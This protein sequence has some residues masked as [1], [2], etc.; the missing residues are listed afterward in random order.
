[1]DVYIH[2][3]MQYIHTYIVLYSQRMQT[4]N[5]R[6]QYFVFAQL[7]SSSTLFFNLCLLIC[8]Y[9]NRILMAESCSLNV[10]LS[11]CGSVG[12][13]GSSIEPVI[14]EPASSHENQGSEHL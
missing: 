4:R 7:I 14:P 9:S 6:E 5:L 2:I 1:M 3:Y 13:S 10:N 12:G 11:L 8:M